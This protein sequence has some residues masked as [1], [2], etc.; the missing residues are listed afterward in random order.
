MR[1][2]KKG[3]YILS[4]RK[5]PSF[6]TTVSAPCVPDSKFRISLEL[7]TKSVVFVE[8]IKKVLCM[9]VPSLPR[10]LVDQWNCLVECMDL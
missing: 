3:S 7:S 10:S 6:S 9:L 5:V 1:K 8:S 4:M 2:I